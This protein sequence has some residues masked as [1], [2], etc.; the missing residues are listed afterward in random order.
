M[1]WQDW[2]AAIIDASAGERCLADANG[3]WMI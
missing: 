2:N 3:R 1:L